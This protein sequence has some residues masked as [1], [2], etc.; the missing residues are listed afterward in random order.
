MPAA[1]GP[2]KQKEAEEEAQYEEGRF[3]RIR[4]K[5]KRIPKFFMLRTLNFESDCDEIH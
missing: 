5:D 3:D 1:V 2:L 4:K